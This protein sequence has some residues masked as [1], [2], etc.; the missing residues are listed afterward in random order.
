M[1][2]KNERVEMCM[3]SKANAGKSK[4]VRYYIH[5]AIAIGIMVFARFIPVQYPFTQGGMLVLGVLVGM[6]YS[7]VNGNLFWGSI[8]AL[9]MVGASDV[10]SV[11]AVLSSAMSNGTF[12]FLLA[13]FLFVGHLSNVGF[14]R[15]LALKLVQSNVTKGRPWVLTLFLIL[16]AFL[17][18]SVMSVTAVFVMTLPILYG[19]CDEVGI[20]RT[21]KWSV[22]TAIGIGMA[23]ALAL[24]FWPFQVGPAILFGQLESAGAIAEVPFIQYVLFMTVVI[25]LCLLATVLIIK[26]LKPDVS[27]LYAYTPPEEKVKFNSDQKFATFLVCLLLVLF[28]VPQ[29]LPAGSVPRVFLGQFGP[30][31]IVSFLL[32]IGAFA[33]KDGKPRIDIASSASK[34]LAMWPVLMMVAAVLTIADL[35]TRY[36]LGF[37][38]F[39]TL[40]IGPMFDT[41]NVLFFIIIVLFVALLLTTLVQGSLVMI[42]MMPIM[43]PIIFLAGF[44]PMQTV[45]SFSLVVNIG[46]VLPSGHPLGAVMHGHESIGPQAVLKYVPIFMLVFFAIAVI[47]GVPLGF[48]IF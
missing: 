43:I 38:D 22:L 11:G 31:A 8:I 46:I 16:A 3:S 40:H 9:L 42:I 30:F 27:K 13:L 5:S 41:G 29:F 25:G 32:A 24:A 21:E 23:C 37:V 17:P 34:G 15:V 7:F 35:L 6:I 10:T 2:V 26:L 1:F 18:A 4:D 44:T 36:D 14:S 39:V 47:V 12:M 28:I 45:A 48:L 33:R 20:G 19:I